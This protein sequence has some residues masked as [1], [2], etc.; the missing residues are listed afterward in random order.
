LIKRGLRRTH[1]VVIVFIA[2]IGFFV[3]FSIAVVPPIIEQT[4]SFTTNAPELLDS[5]AATT[6][7]LGW[8]ATTRS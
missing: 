4:A 1:A 6:P 8:S 2:V 5:W 3:G 7:S